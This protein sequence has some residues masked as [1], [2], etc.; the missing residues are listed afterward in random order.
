MADKQ[1]LDS[2]GVTQ[3]WN[4]CKDKFASKANLNSYVPKSG[5]YMTGDL[6][7]TNN[8]FY[9]NTIGGYFRVYTDEYWQEKGLNFRA[10]NPI[11]SNG[12]VVQND[13]TLEASGRHNMSGA[14]AF[15]G[16]R[17]NQII[18]ERSYD[19]GATWESYEDVSIYYFLNVFV[20][21]RYSSRI[22]PKEKCTTNAM[23]RI[24]IAS[25]A[26]KIPSGT[27]EVDKLKHMVE[28]KAYT[29][30]NRYMALNAFYTYQSTEQVRLQLTVQHAPS[31]NT[32]GS[33][34][35][36]VTDAVVNELQGWSGGGSFHLKNGIFFGN[37]SARFVRLIFRVQAPDGSFD[38]SKI[39]PSN[40]GLYEICAFSGG[41]YISDP[42]WPECFYNSPLKIINN[43]AMHDYEFVGNYI[44]HENKTQSIGTSTR[45]L[46]EI[47]TDKL[48]VSND[49]YY[50][51]S[52]LADS[53]GRT[54]IGYCTAFMKCRNNLLQFSV[55]ASFRYKGESETDDNVVAPLFF[56]LH[57]DG[58][59]LDF[60]KS[61]Q[62]KLIDANRIQYGKAGV[63]NYSPY[64]NLSE[65][66]FSFNEESF[67]NRLWDTTQRIV[68]FA[69]R[70]GNASNAPYEL[71]LMCEGTQGGLKMNIKNKRD[72]AVRGN[73]FIPLKE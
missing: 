1:Y 9:A 4:A 30:S 63:A 27:K 55:S 53:A 69:C 23:F 32:E 52:H 57:N 15:F 6:F 72:I 29:S 21:N 28:S 8:G 19:A 64:S 14:N 70:G 33:E 35:T 38:N 43:V 68:M 16:V 31:N 17:T 11:G 10:Y 40:I 61:I 56:R 49:F 25:Q 37:A 54:M 62:S 22:I 7:N 36:F 39:T 66:M 20:G 58:V 42:Q 45:Y 59:V 3:I 71:Q 51:I 46:K 26:Y 48:Y 73:L 24:T 47:Y 67:L 44:P 60:L 13:Y 41:K 65:M 18:L 5:T 34:P 12:G 50:D 2:A